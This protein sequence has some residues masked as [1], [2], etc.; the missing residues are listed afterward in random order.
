MLSYSR[1]PSRLTL[2]WDAMTTAQ[3]LSACARLHSTS[4]MESLSVENRTISTCSTANI[5]VSIMV[6]CKVSHHLTDM[7]GPQ[8]S[9]R[10]LAPS[11]ST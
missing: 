10:H 5:S 6:G 4:P 11:A 7:F 8:D 2:L 1:V 9:V 3:A